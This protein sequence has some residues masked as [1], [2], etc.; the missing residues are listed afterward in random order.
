[1]IFLLFVPL[2]ESTKLKITN[3]NSVFIIEQISEPYGPTGFILEEIKSPSAIV[4]AHVGDQYGFVVEQQDNEYVFLEIVTCNG[5]TG[6]DPC[7]KYEYMICV[8]LPYL[9]SQ[10]AKQFYL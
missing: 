2:Y 6:V 7:S 5:N 8:F 3:R 9:N 1:M 10:E 4:V